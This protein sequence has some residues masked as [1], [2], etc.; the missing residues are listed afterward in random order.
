[1]RKQL[2]T[3]GKFVKGPSQ[4]HFSDSEV[5]KGPSQGQSEENGSRDVRKR[6]SSSLFVPG[7]LGSDTETEETIAAKVSTARRGRPRATKV[8]PSREEFLKPA[9]VRS[10]EELERVLRGRQYNKRSGIVTDD[11]TTD[12]ESDAVT[13][14]VD[15]STLNAQELRAHAG[16]GLACILEVAKKSGNLKGEFVGRLKRSASTLREVV[17][18]LASRSEAEETR[19]LRA[20]NGRLKLEVEAQKA[21]VKALRRGF[22]EAKSEAAAATTAAAA[23]AV[24]VSGTRTP[25]VALMGVELV[26][27]LRRSLT[28]TLGQIINARFEGIEDRL[29]PAPTVRPP[30]RADAK[31]AAM[32]AIP[33]KPKSVPTKSPKTPPKGPMTAATPS[34]ALAG[35]SNREGTQTTTS[36]THPAVPPQEEAW[37]MVKKGKRK[38]KGKS[39]A[40]VAAPAPAADHASVAAPKAPKAK[41]RKTLRS[42]KTAAVVLS[43]QPE[44]AERGITYSAILQQAQE[45]VDLQ[46]LGIDQLRFRQTATGARM[47]EIPGSQNNEKADRLAE[48]LRGVLSEVANIARPVK[49]TDVRVSGLDDTATKEGVAAAV[50][51]ATGCTLGLVRAGEIRPGFGGTGSTIVSCPIATAKVLSQKGTLLIGWS[52]VRVVALEARPMRCFRCMGLGHTRPQCTASADR[53]D[54]CFRCGSTGH[55]AANC[56]RV[57]PRCAICAESGR[58]SGHVM[59]GRSCVP[60]KTKGK[61]PRT[62]AAPVAS[63]QATPEEV[64][65]RVAGEGEVVMSE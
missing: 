23:A 22:T 2:R 56:Q 7:Y 18:A 62:R 54:L 64:V 49:L 5:E 19:R 31:K 13:R 51:K 53:G 1:M 41:T 25:P 14:A 9:P 37:V 36:T 65:Q 57:T 30:L 35:P 38:G 3:S 20:E 24:S 15:V 61:A 11:N 27:E 26:E 40:P 12:G 52:S 8:G 60:P 10:D 33:P 50:A 43:L 34:V 58:P 47:L 4:G 29:L 28:S 21:E 39:S 6:P 59:G 63:T 46:E 42:P 17:D 55:K 44:A 45:K 48:K 16:E 32:A